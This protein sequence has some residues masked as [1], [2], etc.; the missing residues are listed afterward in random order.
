[1]PKNKEEKQ[2][3]AYSGIALKAIIAIKIFVLM[4][5]PTFFALSLHDL[6]M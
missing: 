6:L 2:F 3:T 5:P 4:K 1:M